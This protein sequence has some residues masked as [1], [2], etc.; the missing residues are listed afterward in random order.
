MVWGFL[1]VEQ[2]YDDDIGHPTTGYTAVY[3]V[4]RRS[5][6]VKGVAVACVWNAMVDVCVDR[7]HG[8]ERNVLLSSVNRVW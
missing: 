1:L 4:L 5:V 7:F 6:L 8:Y 3:S 2:D